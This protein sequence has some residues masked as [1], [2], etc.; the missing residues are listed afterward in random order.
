MSTALEKL[1]NLSRAFTDPSRLL[2]L[3]A[4]YPVPKLDFQSLKKNW[5][6]SQGNLSGHLIKLEKSGYV[7]MEKTFKGKFPQTWCSLT[8]KGRDAIYDYAQQFKS[9]VDK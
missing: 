4:L 2:I 6:F 9:V 8:K 7:K 1:F 5:R 3:T